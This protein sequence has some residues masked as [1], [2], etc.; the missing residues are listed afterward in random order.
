MSLPP[1]S[2][3]AS[4]DARCGNV[5][6]L[7]LLA[8]ALLAGCRE[9]ATELYLLIDTDMDYG[10][11]RRLQSVGVAARPC[12]GPG[13][14]TTIFP[15]RDEPD[16]Y[17]LPALLRLVPTSGS[18]GEPLSLTIT[19]RGERGRRLFVLNVTTHFERAM[20]R[21]VRVHLNAELADRCALNATQCETSVEPSLEPYVPFEHHNT[22]LPPV[23][24]VRSSHG[25]TGPAVLLCNGVN[26]GGDNVD[27]NALEV[28]GDG[29]VRPPFRLL[30]DGGI[31]GAWPAP[32]EAAT[33]GI[34]TCSEGWR[35]LDDGTCDPMLRTDCPDGSSPLPG[36]T[37]TRTALSDCPASEYADPGP[38]ALGAA[39]VHVRADADA[40]VADG[41]AARP[42][43]SLAE[44]MMHAANG[45]WVL[46]AAGEYGGRFGAPTGQTTHVLG[47]CA[48][49]V[50][51]RGPAPTSNGQATLAAA[52]E[53]T[54]L[55]VQGVTVTGMRNGVQASDRAT[56][57]MAKS[58][59]TSNI[60]RGIT[61]IGAGTQMLLTESIVQN[62]RRLHDPSVFA[63]DV[64][65]GARVRLE[66]V[67]VTRNNS[68]GIFADGQGSQ[69][70]IV[71]SV[72]QS[73]LLDST[74]SGRLWGLFVGEGVTLHARG[75]LVADNAVGI[76]ASGSGALAEVTRSIIRGGR[77]MPSGNGYSGLLVAQGAIL[78]L[79]DVL[80]T[81]NIDLGMS[82]Q[83]SGTRADLVGSVIRNT[84][85]RSGGTLGVGL[86][87]SGG[88]ELNATRVLVANNYKEGIS[89]GG[90]GTVAFLDSCVVRD[91][92]PVLD[93]HGFGLRVTGGAFL[94]ATGI[95]VID[96]NAAGV[97][98]S[99]PGT[100]VTL[101]SAEI[102]GTHQS[103][104]DA[105]SLEV[106]HTPDTDHPYGYGLEIVDGATLRAANVLVAG[107]STV[108]VLASGTHTAVELSSCAVR[109]TR[110]RSDGLFGSGLIVASG[111]ELRAAGVLIDHNSE[112]GIMA[113]GRTALTDVIIQ[114]VEPS[115]RGLGVGLYGMGGAQLD[116]TRVAIQHVRGAGL[117][118]IPFLETA[119]TQISI[120]DLLVR[121]VR[122]STVRFA[123]DDHTTQPVGDVAAYG[124]YTGA[125][126]T[127]DV[128]RTLVDGGGTGFANA[129]GALRLRQGVITGQR[130]GVGVV[131]SA[132]SYDA[133]RL[134]DV[135]L[136][137][138]GTNVILRRDDLR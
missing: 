5:P 118:A 119:G 11:G 47:V 26:A 97:F 61:A 129:G 58:V 37:C 84:S 64:H 124:L 2:P 13:S 127:I 67:V 39:I 132:S 93:N 29:G 82:V 98:A 69:V 103:P 43:A 102:A 30:S 90:A 85:P 78:R 130:G 138:N 28:K 60:D 87:V 125:G 36:G 50:T 22:W 52:G 112:V 96:N 70:E 57:L 46:V 94:R 121:D 122:P 135:E 49:R 75:V 105:L 42:Y 14:C 95:S 53:G 31:G 81:E 111:A 63:L 32:G 116:G 136:W 117:M 71:G 101:V 44:G 12:P 73:T 114:D 134:E 126:C 83:G 33:A 120:R 106:T 7:V 27:C 133:T 15:L 89:V 40:T 51:L 6:L 65:E 24:W 115:A 109:G 3:L 48:A 10:P 23:G 8:F 80:V 45:G 16:S 77:R 34:M 74:G 66:G 9:S 25:G 35:R 92:H 4:Q 108:G 68:V 72:I 128:S 41:S 38:E 91:T 19:A 17:V 59:V 88:A 123:E 20:S 18:E 54:V 56:V 86:T 21:M 131:N 55:D 107:N 100:G 104:G 99:G 79:T 62:T 1:Q 113:E 110:P 76:Y 137:G